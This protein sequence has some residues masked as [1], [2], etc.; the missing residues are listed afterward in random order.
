MGWRE[1]LG[2]TVEGV[3]GL[4]LP[5]QAE[6]VGFLVRWGFYADALPLARH[7]SAQRPER[8][9]AAA[10]LVESLLGTGAVPEALRLAAALQARHPDEP[11]ARAVQVDALLADGRAPEALE[12]AHVLLAA[13]GPTRLLGLERLARCRAA[14]GDAAGARAAVEEALALAPADAPPASLLRLLDHLLCSAGAGDPQLRARLQQTYATDLRRLRRDLFGEGFAMPVRSTP[15][16]CPPVPPS[17][18]AAGVGE[19]AAVRPAAALG[20]GEVR[21]DREAGRRSG[22]SASPRAVPRATPLPREPATVLRELFG[23]SGFRPG[24]QEVS[25]AVLAG[26]SILSVM[27][28]GAGKSLCYQL[29]AALLPRATVV[30]SPLIALMKDQVDGLPPALAERTALVNST[31]P[32][33]EVDA[34]LRRIAA[35]QCRLIYAAPERLRQW[36]FLDALRR[37]GV[38][39]FVVDEAH[40]LSLW[41]HDFRPDYLFLGPTLRRLGD[42][43]VLAMTATATP[44]VQR[45]VTRRL[46]RELRRI[47]LGVFRPNLRLEVIPARTNEEK[48]GLLVALC[49]G[50]AGAVVVYASS[51]ERCEDLARMLRGKGV[52]ALHYHAGMEREERA[53]VQD[54][55]MDGRVRVIVATVAFGMG[56]DKR[57]V[58]LVVHYNLPR[59]V[60]SYYQEAGRAGRDGLPSRC[61]LL[62]TPGDRANLSRWA[63]RDRIRMEDLSG[64][65]H[66]VRR[67]A[68]SARVGRVTIEELTHA[69]GL[70]ETPVRV[71]LSLLE[72]VGLVTRYLDLPR[73]LSLRLLQQAEDPALCAVAAAADLRPGQSTTVDPLP[74][75][76][77]AGIHPGE[78]EGLVLAWQAQGWVDY[79]PAGRDLLLAVP[80]PPPGA[81][82]ALDRL[83]A[84]QEQAQ[85][86][87][88]D[89]IAAYV[90]TRGCRHAF[91][92]AEFGEAPPTDCRACDN[93]RP[94]ASAAMPAARATARSSRRA[95]AVPDSPARVAL[96][97]LGALPF[98]VGK[99]GLVNILR[100]SLAAPISP[101]RCPQHG[102]LAGLSRAEVERLV[103]SLVESGQLQRD[104]H[105]NRPLLHLSAQGRSALGQSESGS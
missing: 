8:V 85:R 56:V 15:R 67:M 20:V 68:G 16:E 82:A 19:P 23:H 31:L 39:L 17:P 86:R 45:D 26:E 97:C 101:E 54:A 5:S 72:Q 34:C 89:R 48:L 64:T 18:E 92:A 76:A 75:A 46:G 79:R 43:P 33:G 100:G 38:S 41:G 90:Q 9:D 65:Y 30:I 77:A 84:D 74:L 87:R 57:D 81:R 69:T 47:S 83:L 28:T 6:V 70:E 78:L 94:G 22:P 29:P 10:W 60:E 32:P 102:A 62:A 59:S 4:P 50:E 61:V 95:A 11:A 14:Q 58:R 66:A 42:P 35:G 98:A 63:A 55:F 44:A 49:R 36:P 3:A 25:E 71:A 104:A 13:G 53:A 91:I 103:D 37:A 21:G 40:C 27:P 2:L 88:L 80:P 12:Q 93:C 73:V 96:Q 1:D 7:L 51:R 24:Q 105:S 52:Q 99:K